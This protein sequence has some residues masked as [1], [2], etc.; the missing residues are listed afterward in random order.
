MNVETLNWL[1]HQRKETRME[2]RGLEERNH[3]GLQHTDA[4][5]QHKDN[6]CVF[7]FI[8][9][10]QKCYV[11]LFIFNLFFYKLENRRVK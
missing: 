4:W 2:Y 7:I 5:I 10:K 3:L 6:L 9:Y 8:S 1:G 11:F